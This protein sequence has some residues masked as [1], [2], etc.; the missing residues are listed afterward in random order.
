M[1]DRTIRFDSLADMFG[2]QL[3]RVSAILKTTLEAEFEPLGL[4]TSEATLLIA[5]GESPGRTQTELGR[6]LRIKPANMV[7]LVAKL[8]AAGF[9]DRI[10]GERRAL[11]L[12]LTD[13]G[14]RQLEAVRQAL[15]RH[16]ERITRSLSATE[17]ALVVQA[18]KA[19]ADEECRQSHSQAARLAS[20]GE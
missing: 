15:Q 9:L 1:G 8:A 12:Q 10:P 13:A 19:I 14:A 6:Q 11:A 2:F 5:V 20:A 16:E 3:R 4:R 17:K 18:L 7:P